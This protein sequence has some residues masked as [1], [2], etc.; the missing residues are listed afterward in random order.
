MREVQN[1]GQEEVSDVSTISV[2]PQSQKT[3]KAVVLCV[4]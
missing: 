4:L 1:H 3:C 2:L